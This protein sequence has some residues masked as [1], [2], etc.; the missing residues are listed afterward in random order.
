MTIK[1]KVIE[2]NLK[3]PTWSARD[4]AEHIGCRTEYVFVCKHRYALKFAKKPYR[5][6]DPNSVISLGMAAKRAGL[7]IGDIE[8]LGQSNG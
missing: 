2:L 3:N 8:R 7:T 4:I 6:R 1:E 5:A